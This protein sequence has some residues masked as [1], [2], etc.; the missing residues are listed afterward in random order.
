MNTT[1][2]TYREENRYVKYKVSTKYS[3]TLFNQ[4]KEIIV[5]SNVN[6]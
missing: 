6:E 5:Q 1:A 2:F 4:N 3:T